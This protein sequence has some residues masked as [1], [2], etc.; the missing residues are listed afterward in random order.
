VCESTSAFPVRIFRTPTGYLAWADG[1]GTVEGH[2]LA[3]TRRAAR[4]LVE[5]VVS[6]AFPDRPAVDSTGTWEVLDFRLDVR[7]KLAPG[8]RRPAAIPA[9]PPRHASERDG[10]PTRRPRRRPGL[11]VASGASA[12]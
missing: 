11:K 8:A 1:L 10:G 3:E 12:P 5:T 2:T 7:L 9:D 4:R 6:G